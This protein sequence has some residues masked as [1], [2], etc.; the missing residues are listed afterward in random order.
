MSG[1]KARKVHTDRKGVSGKGI[2]IAVNFLFVKGLFN[3][4][5]STGHNSLSSAGSGL[6]LHADFA[7]ILADPLA[8]FVKGALFLTHFLAASR[9]VHC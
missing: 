9:A 8:H 3:N 4:P 1:G 6:K 7:A 2:D 5:S